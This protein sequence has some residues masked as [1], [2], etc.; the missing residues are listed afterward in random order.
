MS[1]L[2]YADHLTVVHHDDT[3]TRYTAVRYVLHRHGVRVFSDAGEHDFTDV[4]TTHAYRRREAGVP[5]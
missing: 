2:H 3:Q 1:P 5:A 4:L